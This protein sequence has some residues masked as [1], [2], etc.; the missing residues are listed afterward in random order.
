MPSHIQNTF[1]KIQWAPILAVPGFLAL[2]FAWT[3]GQM[4]WPRW[5][6]QQCTLILAPV[7]ECAFDSLF[8]VS[9]FIVCCLKRYALEK[10]VRFFFGCR[11]EFVCHSG[12]I[13]STLVRKYKAI[14]RRLQRETNHMLIAT[15]P[16]LATHKNQVSPLSC[17]S[18][19]KLFFVGF[20]ERFRGK[21][22]FTRFFLLD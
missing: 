8:T 1:L 2:Q 3:C 14:L 6:R 21:N 7:R 18:S 17:I 11:G 4:F 20:F 15:S 9:C 19:W 5:K 10:F 16:K 13:L 12:H 22:I